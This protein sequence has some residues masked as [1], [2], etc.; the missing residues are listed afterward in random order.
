MA[1]ATHRPYEEPLTYG[2]RYS[3]KPSAMSASASLYASIC[4]ALDHGLAAVHHAP[5]DGGVAQLFFP[6][7]PSSGVRRSFFPRASGLSLLN[8]PRV[9][10]LGNRGSARTADQLITAS[11]ELV[12]LA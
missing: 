4:S 2:S 12:V 1:G 10:A 5:S 9:A 11:F 6:L 7:L 8:D 3:S